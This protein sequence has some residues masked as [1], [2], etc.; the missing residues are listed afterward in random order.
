MFVIN[1]HVLIDSLRSECSY[2]AFCIWHVSSNWL[3]RNSKAETS[4]FRILASGF[5]SL[6]REARRNWKTG[7][8]GPI[9]FQWTKPQP[10]PLRQPGGSKPSPRAR[11]TSRLAALSRVMRSCAISPRALPGL[12]PGPRPK[13]HVRTR[14]S[15]DW[16]HRKGGVAVSGTP[17]ALRGQRAHRSNSR[18]D[19][20]D[21]GGRSED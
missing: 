21:P 15:V 16:L 12:K 18:A 6:P 8:G 13:R 20:R 1:D 3:G 17:P 19:R 10:A 2:S 11:P 14:A 4:I 9:L 5:K 7:S